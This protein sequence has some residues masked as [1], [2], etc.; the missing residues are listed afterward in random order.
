MLFALFSL[1][2]YPEGSWTQEYSS[3]DET[4]QSYSLLETKATTK[5]NSNLSVLK[6]KANADLIHVSRK[7]NY[8][9]YVP[10]LYQVLHEDGYRVILDG[11]TF[12][13]VMT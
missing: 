2:I 11:E 6:P 13:Y 7:T 9:N 3:T 5:L 8:I 4:L 10:V 1:I 12:F